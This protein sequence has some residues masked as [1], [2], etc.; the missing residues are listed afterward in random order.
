MRQSF[1]SLSVLLFFG[2]QPVLAHPGGL[3]GSGCHNNR[4]TGDY[5]C[6]GGG[7]YSDDGGSGSGGGYSTPAPEPACEDVTRNRTDVTLVMTDGR[8][9]QSS[10]VWVKKV[11]A[12]LDG[13]NGS[14]YSYVVDGLAVRNFIDD[15]KNNNKFSFANSTWIPVEKTEQRGDTVISTLQPNGIGVSLE[16]YT[17]TQYQDRICR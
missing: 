5:H 13:V 4:R 10:N 7:G 3:N 8:R 11:C 16:E 12:K 14:L 9:K 6:H 2:V 15:T 17:S 1:L